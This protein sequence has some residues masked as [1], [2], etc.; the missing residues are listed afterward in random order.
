MKKK[1][2]IGNWKLNGNKKTIKENLLKI[3]NSN[4]NTKKCKISIA[5]P[6]PYLYLS[7]YILKNN[8]NIKLTSQNIDKNIKGAFTGE[9]SGEMLKDINV[10]YV[11][12][13]HS[14][15]RKYHLEKNKII[16]KKLISSIKTKLTPILCIGE[17]KKNY[18]QKKSKQICKKQIKFLKN[19]KIKNIIK[20]I[21]IAYEPIW[22]IGTG[23]SADINHIND[24]Y[25]T[26]KNYII[27][28][29]NITKKNLKIIYGGSVNKTN[30]LEIIQ[31]TKIDGF[32][33]GSSSLIP[34]EF[35]EIINIIINKI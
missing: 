29:T 15:R 16:L 26:I 27:K 2:V 23:I 17:K 32:L 18:I 30:I 25:N 11:I 3:I 34:N 28:K 8:K 6:I 7:K 12:I 4:I 22:A 13:G 9:I 31:K 14:E 21:I 19:K 35:I 33:I 20:K 1:I 24:I 5:P 10:K